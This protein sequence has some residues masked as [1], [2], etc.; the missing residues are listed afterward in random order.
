MK[1]FGELRHG[2]L[3]PKPVWQLTVEPHVAV[4]VKRLFPRAQQSHTGPILIYDTPEVA[5]DLEWVLTRWPLDVTADTLQRLTAG[6]D[7]HRATEETVQRI[8]EGHTPPDGWRE[9]IREPRHYQSE[10][11]A[12]IQ[13]TG[14]LLVLDELGLGKTFTA[15]LTLRN[16][17]ALPALVVTLT[18]LPAQWLA[19]LDRSLP[20]LTGHVIASRTPY[21]PTEKRGVDRQPDVLVT[22]YA[23]L[24]GWGDHLA[25]QVRTVIFDEIQEL[26][27]NGTLKYTAARRIADGASY[28]V[29]LSATPV[30]NY[31]GELHNIVQVVAPDTLGSREEFL[32]EWGSELGNGQVSVRDPKALGS[33]LR[34]QGVM[35]RRTRVQVG[36]ELPDVVPIVHT[37]DTDEHQLE[38]LLAEADVAG[39][40]R[41]ILNAETS[42]DDRWR[43]SGELDWKLRHA[44]GV[45][46]AAYV[47]AF[48][49]L[50]LE[51]EEKVVLFG[52]HRDV[53]DIWMKWLIPYRPVLYTG[54][55]SPQ[56]KARA[57]DAFINGDARVLVMSLRA[58]AGLDGLQEASHV[59][60]FGELDWSPGVHAQCV[61]RL[62]RDGQN[63]PVLAYYLVSD[64]GSDPVVMDVLGVKRRQSDPIVD[65]DAPLVAQTVDTSDRIRRLAADVLGPAAGSPT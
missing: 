2:T 7:A 48:V 56:M 3:G 19:E 30:Y 27:H 11:A 24:D 10:A 25:G 65:P 15:L 8:L 26:R 46:K 34:D 14:R 45:A 49:K 33:Y 18:H 20:W 44:T 36:R 57:A 64:S 12:I 63:D 37:I 17:A 51:S 38:A 35:L 29:G 6:A 62:H 58:G 43:A 23:K 21:D 60:V 55:E 52:W 22:N 28:R 59:A 47:A 41:L 31:G 40:A 5:R 1:T 4:K 13:A 54:T 9:P 39:V 53:Y 16:P 32:R 42:R 61:G 50:L